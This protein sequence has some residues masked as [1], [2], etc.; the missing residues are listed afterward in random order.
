MK[1]LMITTATLLGVS[2]SIFAAT[3][4]KAKPKN[5]YIDRY[6]QIAVDEFREYR[7]PAS[8]SMAQGILESGWGVGELAKVNNHFGVKCHSEW[9]GETFYLTDDDYDKE[10][11]LIESCFRAYPS[12]V[13]SYRDHSLFL[14]KPRYQSLYDYGV[15]YR[16]WAYGLQAAKYATDTLYA[17][18]LIK[19]IEDHELYKLDGLTERIPAPPMAEPIPTSP[20]VEKLAKSSKITQGKTNIDEKNEDGTLFGITPNDE[21]LYD[22]RLRQEEKEAPKA[23]S[24]PLDYLR[25]QG[26]KIIKEFL[27]TFKAKDFSPPSK[28][29][30]PSLDE[31]DAITPEDFSTG[32]KSK[33]HN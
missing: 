4:T 5:D 27:N 18:K 33:L 22:E 6:S 8:I 16:D 15:N 21:V 11:N 31:L 7:V 9:T 24:I 3:S 23:E 30:Q 1:K 19:L 13:E 14:Q 2:I 17:Q 10:G 25:G 26:K 20:N 12:V 29:K 32:E 28:A